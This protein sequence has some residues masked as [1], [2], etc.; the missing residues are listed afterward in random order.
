MK[1]SNPHYQIS[2]RFQEIKLP[3]FDEILVLGSK[4]E[5]GK[6]GV[7]KT[8]EHLVPEIFE[9]IEVPD[10]TIEAIFVNKRLLKKIS[11]EDILHILREKVFPYVSAREI[12]KVDLE[13]VVSYDTIEKDG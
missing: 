1:S 5:Q 6:M 11:K 4:S 12:I 9:M 8:F 13:I 2:L 7:A 10:D 3:P